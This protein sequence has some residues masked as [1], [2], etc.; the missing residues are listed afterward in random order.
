MRRRKISEQLCDLIV[1]HYGGGYVDYIETS[2]IGARY[3]MK[4]DDTWVNWEAT[5]QLSGTTRRTSVRLFSWD[6]MTDCV[7]YGLLVL[8]YADDYMFQVMAN[9]PPSGGSVPRDSHI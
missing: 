1:A 5:H 2:S 3:W 4:Y 6:T 7:R 9:L 8:P